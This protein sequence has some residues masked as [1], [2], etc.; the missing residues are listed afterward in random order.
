MGGRPPSEADLDE[1]YE[2]C[3][4]S[5]AFVDTSTFAWYSPLGYL[6]AAEGLAVG[7]VL[8]VPLGSALVLA[9]LSNVVVCLLVLRAAWRRLPRGRWAM[10]A[11]VGLPVAAFSLAGVTPDGLTLVLSC[12]VVSGA[13][14]RLLFAGVSRREAARIFLSSLAL[15]LTKPGYVLLAFAHLVPALAVRRHGKERGA[16]ESSG[17]SGGGSGGGT[18]QGSSAGSAA[19]ATRKAVPLPMVA[20]VV[21]FAVACSAA[22]H[23]F[24]ASDFRCDVWMFGIAPDPS[25]QLRRLSD[26]PWA[27]VVAGVVALRDH[28]VDWLAQAGGFAERVAPTLTKPAVAATAVAALAVT[29]WLGERSSGRDGDSAHRSGSLVGP[30]DGRSAGGGSG[31]GGS[32]DGGSGAD[33]LENRSESG[34]VWRTSLVALAAIAY[35]GIVAGWLVYCSPPGLDLVSVPHARVLAPLF[36]PV[37]MAALVGRVAGETTVQKTVERRRSGGDAFAALA[38]L[39]VVQVAFLADVFTATRMR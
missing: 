19:E 26:E 20:L 11:V 13:L 23:A 10:V 33:G 16:Q 27:V 1:R 31:D 32:G 34:L 9:R 38:I 2:R 12:Y 24:A 22:W 21:V 37:A 17:G 7:R 15:G 28:G 39:V 4:G 18:A 35:L 14:Q 8:G 29:G 36:V 25:G 5:R 30:G 6:P 3:G